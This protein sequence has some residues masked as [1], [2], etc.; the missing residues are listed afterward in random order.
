MTE[1]PE[2]GDLETETLDN[3]N[4]NMSTADE[5]MMNDEFLQEAIREHAKFLGMDPD[6][7]KEY[8]YIAEEALTAPLPDGWQQ[9][10][11]EDGTPYHFNADTGESLWEHPL[12]E[13]YRQKFR[14]AKKKSLQ[15]PSNSANGVD[16]DDGSAAIANVGEE[17]EELFPQRQRQQNEEEEEAELLRKQQRERKQREEREEENLRQRVQ[18]ETRER[19]RQLE[20]QKQRDEDE[21]RRQREELERQA[22]SKDDWLNEI[23]E[24]STLGKDVSKNNNEVIDAA[25]SSSKGSPTKVQSIVGGDWDEEDEEEENVVLPSRTTKAK[26][27]AMRLQAEAEAARNAA[28]A[29]HTAAKEENNK[30]LQ[31][32]EKK[33]SEL[34]KRLSDQRKEYEE[35]LSEQKDIMLQHESSMNELTDLHSQE[36]KELTEQINSTR[37]GAKAVNEAHVVDVE[38]LQNE[39]LQMREKLNLQ[40][41][42]ISKYNENMLKKEEFI[43]EQAT[44]LEQLEEKVDIQAKQIVSMTVKVGDAERIAAEAQGNVSKMTSTTDEVKNKCKT[45]E[46]KVNV[47]TRAKSALSDEIRKLVSEKDTLQLSLNASIGE[48]ENLKQRISEHIKNNKK[49]EDERIINEKNLNDHHKR[50]LEEMKKMETTRLNELR[51]S[52]EER[53]ATLISERSKASKIADDQISTITRQ[54]SDMKAKAKAVLN[55]SEN[56]KNEQN[57]KLNQALNDKIEYQRKFHIEEELNMKLKVESKDNLITMEKQQKRLIELER[58]CQELTDKINNGKNQKMLNEQNILLKKKDIQIQEITKELNDLKDAQPKMQ[59]KFRIALKEAMER[60]AEE[61]T[62]DSEGAWRA[63]LEKVRAEYIS[64]EQQLTSDNSSCRSRLRETNDRLIELERHSASALATLDVVKREN[65]SLQSSLDHARNE[66]TTTRLQYNNRA[67]PV[68]PQVSQQHFQPPT[69]FYSTQ[70]VN[71]APMM[72][73]MP[74]QMTT[75]DE[76]QKILA[77]QNQVSFYIF[78]D[79]LGK[80]EKLM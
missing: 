65:M 27:E 69:S 57:E 68:A 34:R 22:S 37:E 21:R 9:A 50:K 12:D 44:A 43:T 66:L 79:F 32:K 45:L 6:L 72:M 18:K 70:G 4:N 73:G 8:L 35:I 24:L 33:I 60:A 23:E 39:I 40:I 80:V 67:A 1:W 53:C 77:I 16:V 71:R 74:P 54:F 41:N 42:E 49:M 5:S 47:L 46:N 13:V 51:K 2:D 78:W 59:D 55:D 10:E 31:S 30:L 20:Q 15:K 58:Q 64:R 38:R 52:F 25:H 61:A 28:I 14:D 75:V 26:N 48:Q 29:A 36:I 56:L 11:A 76:S 3:D 19:E 63:K 17:E 62:S 7:D